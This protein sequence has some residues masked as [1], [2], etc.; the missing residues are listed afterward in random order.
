[1]SITS[2]VRILGLGS[3]LP[4]NVRRN[5]D[6]PVELVA[7]WQSGTWSPERAQRALDDVGG[8]GAKRIL[9]AM[10]ELASDPFQGAK[11]RRYLP[12]GMLAVDMEEAAANAA[13]EDAGVDRNQIEF[14]LGSTM[15]P[16]LCGTSNAGAL[17]LRLG[18]PQD[19][20]V[21]TT[22][23]GCNSFQMQLA[24]A[25]SFIASGRYRMGLLTQSSAIS[26]VNPLEQPFSVN[27]GD[28]ATA[29]VVGPGTQGSGLLSQVHRADGTINRAIVCSVP[30]ADWWE[31]GRIV[32][33]ILDREA[34]RKMLLTI[35][36]VAQE[37]F[38]RAF[39]EAGVAAKDIDFFAG[40][41]AT[42]WWRRVVQEHLGL[43][44]ARSVDTF[45]HA[46][47][48]SSANLP[49]ILQQAEATGLLSPGDLV[50]MYQG[51]TGA[52]YT[53]SIYRW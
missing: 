23:A 45:E 9:E 4:D 12:E 28:G 6:W 50:A 32:S 15:I 26:R 48:I 41:Q 34:A 21:L 46:G 19:C 11:E 24:L 53:A 52:T 16:D 29:V 39:E 8:D 25:R 3:Y 5:Q 47:T 49:L 14:L 36:D 18:L 30:G 37:L 27:F 40:H 7:Q 31:E 2:T 1:M 38:P 17:H 43:E 20:F 51:G 42:A 10:A 44:S 22:D 33:T 13:L 35:C